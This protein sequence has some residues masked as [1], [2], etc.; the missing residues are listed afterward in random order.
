[1]IEVSLAVE[2]TILKG[3]S[4][5]GPDFWIWHLVIVGVPGSIVWEDAIL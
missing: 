5:D 3:V 2:W 4:V 1:M